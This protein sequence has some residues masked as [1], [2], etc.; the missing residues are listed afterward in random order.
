MVVIVLYEPFVTLQFLLRRFLG[1]E[2]LWLG[3]LVWAGGGGALGGGADRARWDAS[4]L[5][6]QRRVLVGHLGWVDFLQ[7]G[8]HG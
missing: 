6:T 3:F 5:C 2:S 4:V 8:C 7:T 1:P